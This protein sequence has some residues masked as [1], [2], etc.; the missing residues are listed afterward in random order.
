MLG[1]LENIFPLGSLGQ[2]SPAERLQAIL[3]SRTLAED[4]IQ[5]LDL[6]PHLFAKRWDSVQ[7]QWRTPKAPTIHDAVRMLEELVAITADRKTGMVAIV[8]EHTDAKLAATI[9]NQ[10]IEALQRILNDNA[11]SLA[12]KNRLFVDA[13]VQKTRQELAVAEEGLRQFEQ[14]HKIIALEAQAITVVQTIAALEGEIMAKE[15]QLQ[16]L[17]RSITGASREVTLLQE[18]LQGLRA[19]L[20]RLQHGSPVS[21]AAVGQKNNKRPQ[22]FPAL[23]EAPEIKLQYARLQRE[24]TIQNKLFTLLMQQL[25]QAKIEEVRDETAFQVLDAAIP[26]DKRVKPKRRQNLSLGLVVGVFLGM[27][28]AFVREYQDPTIRTQEQVEHRTGMKLL[29]TIPPPGPSQ[30]RKRSAPSPETSLVSQQPLGAPLVEAYRYLYTRLKHHGNGHGIRTIVLASPGPDEV[31]PATLVNLAIAAANAGDKT[32]L[33]DS[34]L[35][36]PTLHRL[37]QCPFT[38]GLVE[39]LMSPDEWQKGIQTTAVDNLSL[40]P[41]GTTA[42][43]S[44]SS[45]PWAAFDTVLARCADAYDL[46]LFAVPP[47]RGLSDA[48]M[49]GSRVEATCLVLTKGLTRLDAT[50]EAKATLEAVHAR[51]IG[52]ILVAG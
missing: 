2:D 49:L 20:A 52:A 14:Q 6:L 48:A 15:V 10:Y 44:R 8:V 27:C 36:Q 16:V 12:K 18:E 3:Y 42:S 30:R 34:N 26:S 17:Q 13:Q 38:P 19:Q 45:P 7:Q 35:R 23:E 33:V 21:Q 39:V 28:L 43:L 11:F 1:E 29:A 5:R 51:V 31:L 37:L 46:V 24:A 22:G 25:E 32:L 40:L 9:A 47:V 41:A 4:V 50:T